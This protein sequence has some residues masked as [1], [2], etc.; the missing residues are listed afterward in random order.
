M[1]VA[2]V[3]QTKKNYLSRLILDIQKKLHKHRIL[4]TTPQKQTLKHFTFR[5]ILGGRV[6]KNTFYA[7]LFNKKKYIKIIKKNTAMCVYHKN[8]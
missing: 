3:T 6:T 7:I 5:N 1:R 2:F 8:F 4:I